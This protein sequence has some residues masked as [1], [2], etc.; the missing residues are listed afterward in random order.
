MQLL[1]EKGIKHQ[2]IY[3][4]LTGWMLY[5]ILHI[6]KYSSDYTDADNRKQVKNVIKTLFFGLSGE[7]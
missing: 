6:N 1:G 3:F 4:S 7:N 5:F 2:H